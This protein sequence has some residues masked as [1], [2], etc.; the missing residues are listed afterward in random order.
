MPT[1][2]KTAFGIALLL[3]TACT[4]LPKGIEP[5]QPFDLE[6]YLG[7]WYE[8]ARLDHRFER[9]LQQVS[10]TYSL[11]EDG[12]V[13]VVNRGWDVEKR[14]WSS[15]EGRA[16][17]VGSDNTAHLKVSFFGP[18]YGSYAV[19]DLDADYRHASVTGNDR[20]YLW[21]L[22]RTPEVSAAALEAFRA[23]AT[24][25]GFDLADLVIVDQRA[26]MA[27]MPVDPA[28]S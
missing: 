7:T 20:S 5:V 13:R 26:G 2:H 4:G 18:F 24:A 15:A 3:L 21:F 17:F 6:R 27:R 12:T 16:M 28:G 23:T 14:E 11:R 10:A 22:S 1:I 8:I 25:A 9:G 19:F